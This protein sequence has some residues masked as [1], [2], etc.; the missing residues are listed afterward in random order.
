MLATL[1]PS[2]PDLVLSAAPGHPQQKGDCKESGTGFQEEEENEIYHRGSFCHKVSPSR[3]ISGRND[4]LYLPVLPL[5]VF[6]LKKRSETLQTLLFGE[7]SQSTPDTPAVFQCVLFLIPGRYLEGTDHGRTAPD[8]PESIDACDDAKGDEET[9][10]PEIDEKY[11]DE[12]ADCEI[13]S[14]DNVRFLIMK[15]QIQSTRYR[16]PLTH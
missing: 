15:Y 3:Y 13:V 9:G 8:Q 12:K 14:S 7:M 10:E 11:N 6:S 1:A 4:V 5:P 16:H 2:H